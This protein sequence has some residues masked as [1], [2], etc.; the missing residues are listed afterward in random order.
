MDVL[1]FAINI[2]VLRLTFSCL[3]FS[4]F[5]GSSCAR[6]MVVKMKNRTTNNIIFLI[7]F[8][9]IINFFFYYLKILLFEN[10]KKRFI[11]LNIVHLQI[12]P[13]SNTIILQIYLL[14]P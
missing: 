1:T 3:S 8:F 12:N 2:A 14:T 7:F 9:K 13:S 10:L 5:V 6:I 11:I 4:V